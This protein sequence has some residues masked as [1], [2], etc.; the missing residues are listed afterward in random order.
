MIRDGTLEIISG[1]SIGQ[2]AAVLRRDRIRNVLDRSD[3]HEH[4]L[5]DA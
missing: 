4:Y 3:D 5:V 1:F 2:G